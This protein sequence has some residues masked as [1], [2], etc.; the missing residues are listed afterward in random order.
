MSTLT[1]TAKGQ[2]TLRK[3][4]L[5][6][7]GAAPGH[8]IRVTKLPGGRIEVQSVKPKRGISELFGCLAG[9]TNGAVAT[10]EEI[11]AAIDDGWAGKR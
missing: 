6:H 5:Q 1:V 9:K 7:L 11:N 10:I 8:K 2:V 4:V 3:D